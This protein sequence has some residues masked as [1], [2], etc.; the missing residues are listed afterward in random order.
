M[1]GLGNIFRNSKIFASESWVMNRP[2]VFSNGL[3][4]AGYP[5]DRK[6]R[7]LVYEPVWERI[8]LWK[9]YSSDNK[10]ILAIPTVALDRHGDILIRDKN[11]N[12]L[13]KAQSKIARIKQKLKPGLA[14][15]T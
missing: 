5:L 11:Y 7:D 1:I 12:E 2:T 9:E 15:F 6:F 4:L 10:K 14:K 13:P 8:G 3:S